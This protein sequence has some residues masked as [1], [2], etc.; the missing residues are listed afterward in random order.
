MQSTLAD[1]SMLLTNGESENGGIDAPEM[2]DEPA[3]VDN[4]PGGL[5]EFQSHW[6][7]MYLAS[8]YQ[9][10]VSCHICDPNIW[11]FLLISW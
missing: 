11:I 7:E 4:K 10:Y 8:L 3:E 9:T 1:D 5:E 6:I 2:L